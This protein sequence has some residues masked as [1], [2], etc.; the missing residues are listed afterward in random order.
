VSAGARFGGRRAVIT[1]YSTPDCHLC[2]DALDHLRA[3]RAELE[4]ELCERDITREEALH[5]AY[6]ERIP[7][8]ALDGEELFDY[9]VDEQILRERLES[10][11]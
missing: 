11:T 5:R 7:V 6:F 4:F 8:V 3:L 2:A 1:V 9:V 10:R